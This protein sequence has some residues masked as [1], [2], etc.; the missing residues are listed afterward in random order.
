VAEREVGKLVMARDEALAELKVCREAL[1]EAIAMME[2]EA[3]Q[4]VYGFPPHGLD[5][6]EFDPDHESCTPEEI[7]AHKAAMETKTKCEGGCH[8]GE[9]VIVT[10]A[11]WGIGSYT[12]HDERLTEIAKRWRSALEG[13]K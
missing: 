5:P 12:V 8:I 2:S 11:A 7:A 6:A 13:V 1:T 3:E 9:H 4:T 10:Q